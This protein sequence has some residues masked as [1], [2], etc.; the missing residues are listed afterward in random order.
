M[1]CLLVKS[2]IFNKK[3]AE[4]IEL[5]ARPDGVLVDLYLEG[6]LLPTMLD[7]QLQPR[8]E[9]GESRVD[10]ET[11]HVKIGDEVDHAHCP[12]HEGD[13]V[14]F[15]RG[16]LDHLQQKRSWFNWFYASTKD[17]LCF[18]TYIYCI[19]LKSGPTLGVALGVISFPNGLALN[20]PLEVIPSCCMRLGLLH[21]P[22]MKLSDRGS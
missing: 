3:E 6:L 4:K 8:D 20:G 11:L 2:M 18:I 14:K 19:S 21:L 15:R 10:L 9:R 5:V 13:V 12:G 1:N 17:R 22:R 7:L 16:P